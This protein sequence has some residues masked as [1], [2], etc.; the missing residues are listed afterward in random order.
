M[1]PPFVT[2]DAHKGVWLL[3][4]DFASRPTS[5]PEGVIPIPASFECDLSSVPRLL[6]P[7]ASSFELSI[8]GPLTHDWLYRHRGSVSV[9]L[10]GMSAPIPHTFSRA[11]ADRFFLDYMKEEGVVWWKRQLAYRA[12]RWFG[13]AAWGT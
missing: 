5:F 11:N 1:T 4:H 2:Y 7:L 12:V 9:H 10:D 6:W 8:G 13:G 3:E